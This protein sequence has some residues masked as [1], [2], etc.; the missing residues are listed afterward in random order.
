[1]KS[2]RLLFLGI[3]LLL[4]GIC[5]AQTLKERDWHWTDLKNG[6]QTA[7]LQDT[8]WGAPRYISVIK[9]SPSRYG[10]QVLDAQREESAPTNVLAA[11]VEAWGAINGSYFNMDDLTSHTYLSIDG[12]YLG[13]P[14]LKDN[15]RID[16]LFVIK[17][18]A[19][20]KVSIEQYDRNT[21]DAIA[22]SNHTVLSAGPLLLKD[23]KRW[24]KQDTGGFALDHHN[25]SVIALDAAGDIWMIVVDSRFEGFCDGM[26][27]EMLIDLC[28]GLGLVDALNL[29]GG[30]SSQ[31]WT[32]VQ[33]TLNHPSD[34]DRFDRQG[35][36]T[37]PNIIYFK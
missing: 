19:G 1:M 32:S 10:T 2:F 15:F 31:I 7:Y 23:G 30:G 26:T 3:A 6:I 5:G 11:R 36:R 24:P 9:Y 33:G 8:L 34:N 13:E 4:S 21:V 29:D 37:V 12:K 27:I 35:G 28:S 20:H 18:K 22:A 16:G 25:R 14:D 17:D